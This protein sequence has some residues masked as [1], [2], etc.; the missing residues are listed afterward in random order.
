MWLATLVYFLRKNRGAKPDDNKDA[1]SPV[2]LT[3][4]NR[5]LET[6]LLKAFSSRSLEQGLD[7]WRHHH[8]DADNDQLLETV[9]QV[10]RFYYGNATDIDKATLKKKVNQCCDIIARQ[11]FE[12]TESC[13]AWSPKS[14]TKSL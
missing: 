14:F 3:I 6:Q 10:Q 9:R 4:D 1:A 2:T 5:P 7:K 11:P 13:D 8:A 12:N